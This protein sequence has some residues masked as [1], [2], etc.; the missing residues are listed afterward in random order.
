MWPD[1]FRKMETYGGNLKFNNTRI[2]KLY[3][4]HYMWDQ[5]RLVECFVLYV[6]CD[7]L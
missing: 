4:I 1:E 6:A 5:M 3:T 2:F 7:D